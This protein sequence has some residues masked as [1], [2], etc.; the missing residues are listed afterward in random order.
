MAKIERALSARKAKSVFYEDFNDIDIFIEDTTIG[1]KKIFKEILIRAFGNTLTIDQIFPLGGRSEV[2]EQCK[3]H[4][5]NKRK[6]LYIIDGDLNL[7]NG[8]Q[9]EELNG[10]YILPRYCIE[11]YLLDEN[12]LIYIIEEEDPELKFETIKEKLGFKEWVNTHDSLLINLF[13]YYGLC[14]RYLPQERTVKFK[15]SQLCNQPGIICETKIK[16]RVEDLKIKLEEQIGKSKLEEEL[17]IIQQRVN[18]SNSR[19]LKFV[20]GKDYLLPL[21]TSKILSFAKFPVGANLPIPVKVRLSKLV[22]IND[23]NN[24]VNYTLN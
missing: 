24:I 10:L 22:D 14:F 17:S 15:V 23:L 16:C 5:T 12:A 11:N 1:Y 2:V 3:K 9:N 8:I 18:L 21:L 19:M 6:Q 4:Q 13:T 7:I 20:S